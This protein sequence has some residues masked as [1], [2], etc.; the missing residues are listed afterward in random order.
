M[1]D[2][3]YDRKVRGTS[4]PPSGGP[5]ALTRHSPPYSSVAQW[6]SIRLLTGGLLV[7]VQPEEPIS[8]SAK[9]APRAVSSS[10]R[11]AA[12]RAPREH[13]RV[14]PPSLK[15]QRPGPEEPIFQ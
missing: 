2:F 13:V 11:A 12:L 7:R 8:R 5:A 10:S 1:A 15:L 6:Q 4:C 9:L 3:R 14:Q